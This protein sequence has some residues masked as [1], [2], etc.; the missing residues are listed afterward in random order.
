MRVP[1]GLLGNQVQDSSQNVKSDFSG[2]KQPFM[3]QN[4]QAVN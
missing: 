1:G 2:E 4:T 3:N